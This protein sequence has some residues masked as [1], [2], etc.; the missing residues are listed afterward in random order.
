MPERMLTSRE[1]NRALLARQMLLERSETDLLKA[2]KGH[3]ALQAQVQNPPYIG[4]WARVSNMERNDLTRLMEKR[5]IVRVPFLRGTIHLVASDD[6]LAYFSLVRPALERAHR[7][8]NGRYLRDLDEGPIVRAAHD[9][10]REPRTLVEIRAHLTEL[11]PDRPPEALASIART[12]LPLVQV[13]PAGSWGVGGSQQ[14][15]LAGEYLGK[16][17]AEDG[18]AKALIRRYL[19]A[20]G[21]ASLKD[22][23]GWAGTAVHKD[24]WNGL[25]DELKSYRDSSGAELFDLPDAPIPDESTPAPVR[26]VPDYDNLILAHSDR[27][28]IIADEHRKRV[29]LSAARVLPTLLIDGFV[30]G[31]WKW[32]RTKGGVAVTVSPFGT[33][34]QAARRESEAEAQILARFIDPDSKDVEVR[35]SEC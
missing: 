3:I 33:L 24:A 12:Y 31:T 34:A 17:P 26:L 4:L 27:T 23:Q 18:D 30:A 35:F 20:F 21:P 19:A 28:R 5:R 1:L 25:R 6:Y 14:Y 10:L 15:A 9:F 11:A 8:F 13:F 16:Q 29:F 7:G 32:E 22:F 2:V